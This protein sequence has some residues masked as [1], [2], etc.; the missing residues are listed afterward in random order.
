MSDRRAAGGARVIFPLEGEV[1][2]LLQSQRELAMWQANLLWPSDMRVGNVLGVQFA[3][4]APA[5]IRARAT[6]TGMYDRGGR[7]VQIDGIV[8][9][10]L[11]I[12]R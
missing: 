11:A 12:S 10:K 1:T 6:E 7:V 9:A 3:I 5:R 4:D 8:V 2:A